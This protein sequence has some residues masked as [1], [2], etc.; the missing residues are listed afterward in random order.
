VKLEG[1]RAAEEMARRALSSMKSIVTAVEMIGR[2][3][4]RLPRF[5]EIDWERL[6]GA[7]LLKRKAITGRANGRVIARK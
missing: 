3:E 5:G 7:G 4:S 2:R 6:L 1:S